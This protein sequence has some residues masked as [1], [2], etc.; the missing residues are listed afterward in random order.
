MKWFG[1]VGFTIREPIEEDSDIYGDK[2]VKRPYYGELT[3]LNSQWKT[4]SHKNDDIDINT[5][6]SIVSDPFAYDHFAS[7]I[8]VEFMGVKWDVK[9]VTPQYPRLILAVG[10]EYNG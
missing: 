5:E 2:I 8:Y 4:S 9:T 7:I 6:I 10:G 3:R 1:N